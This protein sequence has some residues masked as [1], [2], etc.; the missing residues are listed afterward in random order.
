M[1]GRKLFVNNSG[2]ELD[3][4][5]FVRQGPDPHDHAN[6]QDVTLVPRGSQ[7]VVYGNDVNIYLN[8][9]QVSAIANGDIIFTRHI[10]VDR[11]SPLDS[12]LNMNNTVTFTIP[13]GVQ[14]V[15]LTASNR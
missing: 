6:N 13:S 7:D 3:I 4:T 5:I 9:F 1:A 11:G 8:G 15:L 10:V 2:N 14:D 12:Q